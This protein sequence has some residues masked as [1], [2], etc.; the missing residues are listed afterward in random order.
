MAFKLTVEDDFVLGG[1]VFG[2]TADEAQ[3]VEVLDAFFDHGGTMVDTADVYSAWV[4]GNSGG[5]SEEII[6]RWMAA[7]GNRGEVVVS[8]KVGQLAAAEGLSRSSIRAGVE[9]S[10]ERLQTDYID[11]YYAHFDDET[12]PLEETLGALD[13]LVR[14]GK[15]R[16]LAASNYSPERLE[17]ALD[18]SASNG[19]A[20]FVAFQAHYNLVRRAKFEQ[21]YRQLLLERGVAVFPYYS[22][23]QGF[24]TGKYRRPDDG[25][26]V[27]AKPATKYLDERGTALLGVL[28]QVASQRAVSQAA[29][30][31]AWLNAQPVVGAPVAS[32][33]TAAQLTELLQVRGLVLGTDEMAALDEAGW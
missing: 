7:R 10:L 19:W 27:R 1:N 4:P 8:T 26:S 21:E 14:E 9:A 15:V 25:D 18:V 24:L 2:W 12:V 13:E 32:A 30:A 16:Y 6:G 17:A 22:L 20:G 33:R 3:S 29:V 31:L 28:D 5:E 11:I 23:A